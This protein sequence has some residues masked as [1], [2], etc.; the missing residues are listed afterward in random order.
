MTPRPAFSALI[1]L[2]EVALTSHML[3]ISRLVVICQLAWI[4]FASIRILYCDSR[5]YD[6]MKTFGLFVLVFVINT[7]S[8]PIMA[9]HTIDG[10]F[11]SVT[12]LWLLFCKSGVHKYAFVTWV[13]M[14]LL[15]GIAPL[16]KQGFILLPFVIFLALF[17]QRQFLALK[18][19][20]VGIIPP[21]AYLVAVGGLSGGLSDQFYSMGAR[22]H[23]RRVR[24]VIEYFISNSFGLTSVVFYVFLIFL[25]KNYQKRKSNFPRVILTLVS[26]YWLVFFLVGQ[27]NM[28]GY[29]SWTTMLLALLTLCFFGQSM[30]R[31]LPLIT[32]IVVGVAVSMS[33]GVPTPGLLGGTFF[34][35][36]LKILT[37][38]ISSDIAHSRTNRRLF[39]NF[40]ELITEKLLS[41]IM[42][43]LIIPSVLISRIEY[44]FAEPEFS[45]ITEKSTLR[46]FE[47]VRMSLQSREYLKSIDVCLKR[48]PSKKVAL[49]PDNAGL[50]PLLGLRNPFS[51]DW[52]L[53]E[54]VTKD[55]QT[56]FTEDIESLNNS[57]DWLVLMQSYPTVAL[58]TLSKSQVY[59]RGPRFSWVPDDKGLLK[60]LNGEN[61]V[62]NSFIGKY[63]TREFSPDR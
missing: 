17:K 48:Y 29:W 47:W 26:L 38:S 20:W 21:L 52:F 32:L 51:I 16:I 40:N 39:G 61:V 59:Q 15:A 49:I 1:H 12:A 9:W 2:P 50:Y 7:N 10:L 22:E 3:A 35:G 46:N 33:W 44:P 62:C 18:I 34:L 23:Y 4:A 6:N 14:W 41:R 60:R 42:L 11:V 28:V 54:E 13:M 43:T 27:E 37:Q 55:R 30:T 5:I 31:S 8:W 58:R 25:I 53:Q 24:G 63:K 19:S 36:S 56:K 57:Q 45:R